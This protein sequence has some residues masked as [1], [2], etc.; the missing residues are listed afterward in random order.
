MVLQL[1]KDD[2]SDGLAAILGLSALRGVG[3]GI[4]TVTGSA[5]VAALVD[6]RRRGEA[7]GVYGLAVAIP[8]LV[9]LPAGP[10]IA[11]F[12]HVLD[13]CDIGNLGGVMMTR[14]QLTSE[15]PE[16]LCW[17][18]EPTRTVALAVGAVLPGNQMPG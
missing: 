5:A 3:F 11:E 1:R 7:I 2:P 6:P 12:Q 4:L 14:S 18:G 8:N 15:A 10:W 9:L 16:A 13:G 17:R